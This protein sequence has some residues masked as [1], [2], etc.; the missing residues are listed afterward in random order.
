MDH[1][2]GGMIMETS[3]DRLPLDVPG[4]V[5]H[6]NCQKEVI[7]RL[8]DFGLIPGTTVTIRYR[9]PDRGVSALEFRGTVIAL[10]TRDMKGV[11]VKWE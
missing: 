10:R 2:I 6:M 9:S 3:L 11:R 7:W 8:R 1:E 5:V 4:V